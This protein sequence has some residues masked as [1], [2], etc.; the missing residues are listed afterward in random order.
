MA[1]FYPQIVALL[2]AA[3]CTLVRPGKGSHEIWR[4]SDHEPEFYI[5]SND[6]IAPYRE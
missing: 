2:V 4:K 5:A 1:D 6:E 3:G